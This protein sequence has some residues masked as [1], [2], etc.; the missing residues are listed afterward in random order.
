MMSTQKRHTTNGAFFACLAAGL[1][2]GNLPCSLARN[3]HSVAWHWM[4]ACLH[5]H[6]STPLPVGA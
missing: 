6:I 5:V 1:H 2:I 4:P 3:L